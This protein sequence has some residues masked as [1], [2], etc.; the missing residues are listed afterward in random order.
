MSFDQGSSI[1]RNAIMPRMMMPTRIFG[2]PF[3]VTEFNFCNPN[4]YRAEGSPLIGGYAARQNWGGLWRFSWTWS[5]DEILSPSNNGIFCEAND[6][7]QQFGD[8]I[9]YALF[10][11]GDLAPAAEKISFSVPPNTSRMFEF[12]DSFSNLGLHAQIGSH[13]QGKPLPPSVKLF[14]EGMTVKKDPRV[15][16]NRNAGS[17]TITTALTETVTLREGT[18]SAD[19]LRVRDASTFMTVAAISLDKKPLPQSQSILLIHLTNF[20]PTGTRFGNDDKTVLL[21]YG[22]LPLLVEQGTAD[23][24]LTVDAPCRIEALASDGSVVGEI[25]GE[26]KNGVLRFTADTCKFPGG[27]SAY[28]LSR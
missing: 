12:S 24:E 22:R 28:H 14:K 19:K 9:I 6:P 15:K 1:M 2:R 11:R 20:S 23:I 17:L 21:D 13:V 18:L 10:L 3:T 25:K 8:R 27:V 4:V 7:M 5:K 26:F 16:L